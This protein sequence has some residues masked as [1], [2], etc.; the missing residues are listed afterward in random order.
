MKRSPQSKS[1]VQ[2]LR[3]QFPERF[4]ASERGFRERSRTIEPF[5]KPFPLIF[6]SAPFRNRGASDN[7]NVE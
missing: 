6:S 3:E 2:P 1:Y 4:F 5:P 7:F